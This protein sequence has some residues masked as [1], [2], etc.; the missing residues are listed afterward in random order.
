VQSM[1]ITTKVVNTNTIHGEGGVLDPTLV[2]EVCQWLA[3]DKWF[4]L[5]TPVSST[6]KTDRHDIAEIL[7]KVALSK[8]N[9]TINQQP[10]SMTFLIPRL[11]ISLSKEKDLTAS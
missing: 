6:Y 1:H 5:G 3:A 2:D 11:V 4:S 10:L 7:L 8:I 9:Q